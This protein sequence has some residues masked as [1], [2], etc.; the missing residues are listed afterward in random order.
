[1]SEDPRPPRGPS[2]ASH[3]ESSN[4]PTTDNHR[5]KIRRARRG[6]RI[7]APAQK[8][9]THSEPSHPSPRLPGAPKTATQGPRARL[10]NPRRFRLVRAAPTP[11]LISEPP[12]RRAG[13]RG[14]EA[15]YAYV[16]SPQQRRRAAPR[17]SPKP[18]ATA[19]APTQ[20]WPSRPPAARC[21]HSPGPARVAAH[22]P[23]ARR[24][25]HHWAAAA[26]K[27]S[28]PVPRTD[29]AT[30]TRRRRTLPCRS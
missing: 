28:R 3:T 11:A 10:R 9:R 2:K 12:R 13:D 15:S 30:N 16:V 1:M 18:R 5:K 27:G 19:A 20:P 25:V 22:Q 7:R 23:D 8:P 4:A 24:P 14:K 21:H 29:P 26:G 6:R 17:G